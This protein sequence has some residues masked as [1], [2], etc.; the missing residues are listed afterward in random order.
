MARGTGRGIDG[1]RSLE[2]LTGIVTWRGCEDV[3]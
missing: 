3:A 1:G 2:A